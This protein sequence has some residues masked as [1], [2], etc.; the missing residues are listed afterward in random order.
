M[1]CELTTLCYIEKDD[2]YLMLH[3]TKKKNDP[4]HDLWMGV[5]GHFEEGESPEDCVL[6][7]VY[8]ET[9]LTLTD[10]KLRGVVS[11]SD[12]DW[13]EY[14]FL[15]SGYDFKGSVTVC[16]E[17]DLVWVD[18]EKSVTELPIWEGDKIFLRLMNEG[19]PF[20]SLKLHY[21]NKVLRSVVLDGVK[22]TDEQIKSYL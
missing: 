15:Y 16:S 20:F 1:E 22:W 13:Y 3:R 17:G 2:Q 11:F 10:Y 21:E 4:S 12:N 19:K 9:G 6:R 18:K 7:E 14:M 8:E 5:G